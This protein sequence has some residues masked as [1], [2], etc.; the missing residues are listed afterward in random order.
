[1]RVVTL[2]GGLDPDRFVRER[3]IQAYAEALKGA[4]RHSDYLIE[5]ARKLFPVRTPQGKVEAVNFL[6]PHIRRMPHAIV[7]DEFAQDA[8]Q[9]L[10]ID[11]ALLRQELKQAAAKRQG[12]IAV[13]VSNLSECE[14]VLVRALAGPLGSENF[15]RASAAMAEQA[16][17]FEGLGILTAL[18]ELAGRKDADPLEA[19]EQPS[20]RTMVAQLLMREREP[21]NGHELESALVTLEQH[22]VEQRQRRIRGAIGEAERKGD[23]AG[24]TALM[25][26]RMELDR[27]LRELD[28]R[29][30]ELV[31]Q[32]G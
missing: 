3:G 25:T 16:E 4:V 18:Q 6:L 32:G 27:R 23:L 9:K 26:E 2:E 30:H 21:V 29:M 8:A 7:R 13:G 14:R 10:G 1:V 24:V 17:Y 11:S 28:Q 22:F 5:R 19:L 15:Q 31:S 20:A 12:Q